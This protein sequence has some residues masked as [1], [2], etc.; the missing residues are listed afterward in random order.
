MRFRLG[1][2]LPS[3]ACPCC[4]QNIFDD[5]ET[6]VSIWLCGHIYHSECLKKWILQQ[7]KTTCSR[8]DS[9]LIEFDYEN[10]GMIERYKTLLCDEEM[11][12]EE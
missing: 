6:L 10:I 12:D 4:D 3:D 1:W 8:C 7:N 11:S 9:Q 5:K 2:E